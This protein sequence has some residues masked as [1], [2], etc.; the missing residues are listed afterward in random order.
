M[1]DMLNTNSLVIGSA[2]L[3]LLLIVFLVPWG[4][5][6]N[7]S[8]K[9]SSSKNGKFQVNHPKNTVD[10]THPMKRENFTFLNPPA[11]SSRILK[12]SN[13]DGGFTTPTSMPMMGGLQ[14]EVTYGVSVP[15]T[16][17]AMTMSGNGAGDTAAMATW[18]TV[19]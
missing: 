9:Y 16:N 12:S 19:V 14:G 5:K 1:P 17:S 3:I 7:C 6:C 18:R 2:V 10:P 4:G 11:G 15:G 13:L 8:E